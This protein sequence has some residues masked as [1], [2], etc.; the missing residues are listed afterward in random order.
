MRDEGFRP[1]LVLDRTHLIE[2]CAHFSGLIAAIN[3]EKGNIDRA[4]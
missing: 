3:N 1:V 4:R 2:T